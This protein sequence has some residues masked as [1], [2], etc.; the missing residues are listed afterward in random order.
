[1]ETTQI[2]VQSNTKTPISKIAMGSGLTLFLVLLAVII[3]QVTYQ[4]RSRFQAASLAWKSNRG[5]LFYFSLNQ[6]APQLRY[7]KT[8]PPYLPNN[9]SY[10]PNPERP[11]FAVIWGNNNALTIDQINFTTDKWFSLLDLDQKTYTLVGLPQA[12][13]ILSFS[14]DDQKIAYATVTDEAGFNNISLFSVKTLSVSE[15]EILPKSLANITDLWWVFDGQKLLI[16]AQPDIFN[17]SRDLSLFDLA[18]QESTPIFSQKDGYTNFSASQTKLLFL[19]KDG[20]TLLD[21]EKNITRIIY[22]FDGDAY[23]LRCLWVD[24]KQAL[25]QT[26]DSSFTKRQ[27]VL[28]ETEKSQAKVIYEIPIEKR[29]QVNLFFAYEDQKKTLAYLDEKGI[30]RLVKT[31]L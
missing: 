19:S 24:E 3:Y 6:T 8:Q 9:D 13:Q 12:T 1:M 28:L 4:P 23:R 14:P 11:P 22:D 25:C 7:F 29:E 27:F 5:E 20:V 18:T 16:A 2:T 10:L 30:I 15:R 31:N 17:F 26:I 21:L